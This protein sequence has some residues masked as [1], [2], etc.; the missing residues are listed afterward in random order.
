MNIYV[1]K[2]GAMF[3]VGKSDSVKNALQLY[4]DSELLSWTKELT[5][6]DENNM[7]KTYMKKYGVDCVR[8]GS[9]SDAYLPEYCKS[10]LLKEFESMAGETA[11][12]LDAKECMLSLDID[13]DMIKP[14]ETSVRG[15]IN[16][17]Q[18]SKKFLDRYSVGLCQ[19]PECLNANHLAQRLYY[20][21]IKENYDSI[22]CTPG[23]TQYSIDC[24]DIRESLLSACHTPTSTECLGCKQL[25]LETTCPIHILKQNIHRMTNCKDACYICKK[26]HHIDLVCPLYNYLTAIRSNCYHEGNVNMILEYVLKIKDVE[27]KKEELIKLMDGMIEYKKF[28]G[29]RYLKDE[30]QKT[31]ISTRYKYYMDALLKVQQELLACG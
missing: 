22:G 13:I 29:G 23:R 7:V 6:F 3:Y 16:T 1:L 31:F 21:R 28:G 8:G 20:L 2:V 12:S 25:H 17:K 26:P 9:Y 10:F 11:D 24:S 30:G 27:L 18:E 19:N 14:N 4:P 15:D 5:E